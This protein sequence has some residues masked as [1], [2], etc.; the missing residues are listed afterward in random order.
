LPSSSNRAASPA[1]PED[2]ASAGSSPAAGPPGPAPSAAEPG[3]ST[4]PVAAA[5][6]PAT[7]N[8]PATAALVCG[9]LG[10]ALITIPAGLVLGVLGLRRAVRTGRGRVRC[11]VVIALSLAW[12]GAAGY[13]VPHLAAAS[14]PGCMAYKGTALTAYN[15]VVHHASRGA[16]GDVLTPDL[17]TAIQQIDDDATDSRDTTATRSL[18]AV[19]AGLRTVLADA[20]AGVPVP[21]HVLLKLNHGTDR[22]DDACGT[23]RV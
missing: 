5:T 2:G 6:G 21:R 10:G 20:R 14:D 23:L 7:S 1:Q 18:H 16:G 11:W 8:W 4:G 17:T 9:I 15:R 3:T 12:A 13:L 19:S 22:A